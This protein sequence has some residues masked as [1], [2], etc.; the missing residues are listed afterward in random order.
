MTKRQIANR[1]IDPEHRRLMLAYRNARGGSRTA[2]WKALRDYVT[3]TLGAT[4]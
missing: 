3:A 4:K 1:A 2:A